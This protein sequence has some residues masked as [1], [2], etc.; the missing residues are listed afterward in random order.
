M[1]NNLI[2]SLKKLPAWFK[3]ENYNKAK[4]FNSNEWY[5]ELMPRFALRQGLEKFLDDP[6]GMPQRWELIKKEGLLFYSA[7]RESLSHRVLSFNPQ[8][9][10]LKENPEKPQRLKHEF[11]SITSLVN[12]YV[13]M[14]YWL[15]EIPEREKIVQYIKELFKDDMGDAVH[16]PVQGEAAEWI[17]K[18]FDD[19]PS[20][21]VM[22]QQN[23]FAY[24]RVNLDA[25][26]EQIKKDFALWLEQERKRRNCPAP[27]KNFSDAELTSWHESAVLPYL[28]LIFWSQTE[29]TKISQYVI[30]QAIFP[31]AYS[32][33]SDVD[34]LGRLKTTKKKA[35]HLMKP[36]TM[37]LLELQ[38]TE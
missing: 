16:K 25:S 27:K 2:K 1:K 13:Y 20:D 3:L 12:M 33:E 30:A 23:K 21:V 38:I 6:I 10:L 4:Y 9:H 22:G 28:D 24:A 37:R 19:F 36:E 18:P 11:V 8:M 31:E 14:S 17:A 29:N 35:D 32:M 34:P 5:D 7:H 26:D 15:L